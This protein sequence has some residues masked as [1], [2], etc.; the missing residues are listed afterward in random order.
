MAFKRE[1]KFLVEKWEDINE[2]PEE[3]KEALLKAVSQIEANRAKKGKVPCHN[4]IVVNEDEP[5]SEAV[6]KL[7]EIGATD[8]EGM[9]ALL[10]QA[11]KAEEANK[12]RLAGR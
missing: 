8:P 7:I 10:E 5:Y 2:L 4:Y 6:W 12:A 3:G 11:R 1:N 9:K